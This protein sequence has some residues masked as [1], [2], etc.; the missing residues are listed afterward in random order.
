M[1]YDDETNDIFG[2][3]RYRAPEVLKGS[4]YDFRA[5]MWSYGIILF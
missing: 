4:A 2:D 3:N 5:D 1:G